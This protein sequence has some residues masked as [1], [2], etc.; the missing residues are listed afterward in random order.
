M[1]ID[2]HCHLN[3]KKI[4][5]LGSVDRLVEDA[6]KNGVDAMLTICCRISDEFPEILKIAKTHP[7]VWCTV[8]TH[9]HE[10][11]N[12]SEKNTSLQDLIKASSSDSRVVGIG[13]SGLDYYYNNSSI[14]DQKSSFIKH[15]EACLETNLPIVVHARE[16]DDDI[17]QMIREHGQGKLRGVMHCFSSSRKMAEE[18][19]ALGFY[20]S[21][22]G[23]LTFKQA[24]DL[25][26]IARF[27]PLDRLL[28][29]T[30]AP[31]LAPEP[32]R[33]TINQP[34]YVGY[35]GRILAGIKAVSEEKMASICK[36]NF[37]TLFDKTRFPAA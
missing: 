29:E 12:E 11:S 34:A 19:L 15:I 24:T 8:G 18:A 7:N 20:I 3:H 16:A 26:D 10:A 36:E 14:E 9:P 25:R 33:G 21:F 31:Y 37:F 32:H 17:I 2:S 1:W 27:V 13:E 22:S 5:A 4:T 6:G 30:D 28:V 23:I 35:T